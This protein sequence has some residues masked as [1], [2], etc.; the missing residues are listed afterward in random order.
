MLMPE[1]YEKISPTAVLVAF[2][3]ARYTDMPYAGEIYSAARQMTK[4][5]FFKKTPSIFPRL[6]K[7]SPRST[8]RLAYLEGRY[9]SLNEAL[10]S[11]DDSYTVIEIASGL[12]AR[13]LERIS[14]PSVYIETDLPDMLATKQKVIQ[15]ILAEKKHGAKPKPSFLCP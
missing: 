15:K 11:L 2:M 5:Y 13:G 4:P 1:N 9:L 7:F 12:S 8:G 6:A 10:N 14:K 3:R